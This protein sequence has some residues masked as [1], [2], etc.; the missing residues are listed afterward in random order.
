MADRRR[1][2]ISL[3]TAGLLASA[4]S[5]ADLDELPVMANVDSAASTKSDDTTGGD[6]PDDNVEPDAAAENDDQRDSDFLFAQDQ[7]HTFELTLSADD[8]AFLDADPTAEQ[9][10]SGTLTFEGETIPVGIRYKGSVGAFVRCVDAENFLE[11]SGPKVC[12][13]LS[14]KIKIN[15]E[16]PDAELLG[17]RKL[18][19]HA[20]NN[21]GSLVR[22]RLAYWLYREMGV[23]APRSTHA[24][25]IVNGDFVGIFALTENIDGRFTRENFPD[26][27]G[28]LYKEAWPI[29]QAGAVQ[30]AEVLIGSLRTNE[31]DVDVSAEIMQS[32][33]D[34]LLSS[35]DPVA[36]VEQWMDVEA[37]MAQLAV[38]RTIRH[39][40]GPFHW[41]C[42]LAAGGGANGGCG[43]HNFFWY[44]DPTA[45]QVHLI[46]WDLDN[47]FANIVEDSNPVTP[48]PDGVGDITFD[49]KPFAYG[50][51]KLEQRSASCDPL[52]AAWALM[53]DQYAAAVQ[54]LH[55]G[56]LRAEVI[57]PLLDEWE[58]QIRESVAEAAA[59]HED[60]LPVAWWQASLDELRRALRH[61]RGNPVVPLS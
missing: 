13:K 38:D 36:I 6:A 4:C 20:M 53:E 3:I 27:T 55:D 12:T 5:S 8:L 26:G 24:R 31:N 58:A 51:F 30:A 57:D 1:L 43:P 28:N 35:N 25:I 52:F 47:A 19:F 40:D 17:V 15:W 46:P 21:Q 9:Y 33:A 56:P 49:C 11:P 7:L 29:T 2:L 34:E 54:Q 32:F 41:Y 10:V 44:E 39:D 45:R 14:M 42:Q 16:D 61:A 18:Q 59:T 60:A 50:A 48:I 22:E 37:L 23:P